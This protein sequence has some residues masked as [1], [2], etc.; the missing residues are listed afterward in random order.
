LASGCD[1]MDLG[2]VPTPIL[3]YS[4]HAMNTSSG[5]MLTGSHNPAE[6]NGLKMVLGGE[7]LAEEK[8]QTIYKRICEE[9]YAAGQGELFQIEIID[10]YIS[11]IAQSV[12][13]KRPLK[14]AIDCG[15]GATGHIAP[16]L[17]HA[18]GCEVIELFCEVDGNF[19]NHHP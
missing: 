13:L 8:I 14:I 3:Y 4:T 15:N 10:R 17:F 19:P 7:T 6:Y 1:V 12:K 11:H 5:V 9:Q 18:L 16:T 2:M